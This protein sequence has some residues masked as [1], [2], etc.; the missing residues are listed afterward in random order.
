MR[1]VSLVRGRWSGWRRRGWRSGGPLWVA[2]Q[3]H[4]HGRWLPSDGARPWDRHRDVLA[5]KVLVRSDIHHALRLPMVGSLMLPYIHMRV[6]ACWHDVFPVLCERS[7]NLAAHVPDTWRF[8]IELHS[9]QL[10]SG[11]RIRQNRTEQQRD[12]TDTM[13]WNLPRNLWVTSE[14]SNIRSRES[15]DVTRISEGFH[16]ENCLQRCKV[17]TDSSA[18]GLRAWTEIGS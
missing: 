15:A 17:D 1:V 18:W 3:M 13:S 8:M 16:G 6:L 4:S 14:P 5:L 10:K 7:R 9:F 11:V 2:L 12:R